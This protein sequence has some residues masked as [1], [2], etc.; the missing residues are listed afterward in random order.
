M[1]KI[2]VGINGFGRIGRQ[3]M[4]AIREKYPEQIDVVAFNEMHQ[5][6]ILEERDAGAAGRVGQ[7]VLARTDHRIG[8][9]PGEHGHQ[10]SGALGTGERKLGSWACR[11]CGTTANA[12]HYAQYRAGLHQCLVHL[13]GGLQLFEAGR[14]KVRLHGGYE[15]WRIHG[16]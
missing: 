9:H 4:R 14:H 3:V 12:V 8:V 16:F 7:A 10:V 13:F 11:T 6:A 15:L 5:L 2:R 1:A